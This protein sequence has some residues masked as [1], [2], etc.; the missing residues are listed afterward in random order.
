LG[1]LHFSQLWPLPA[2]LDSYFQKADK[3]VV[4]EE[5]VTGQFAGLLQQ[6]FPGNRF[7]SILKYN[8]RHFYEEEIV[9]K[10]EAL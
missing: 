5:N 3:I 6:F 4:I 2:D 7:E 9:E 8:G 1:L 10:L